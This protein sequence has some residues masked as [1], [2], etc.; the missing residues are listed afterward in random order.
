VKTIKLLSSFSFLSGTVDE[1]DGT[2]TVVGAATCAGAV[3]IASAEGAVTP[4]T[5]LSVAMILAIPADSVEGLTVVDV[6]LASGRV[7]VNVAW[8]VVV[9]VT[10]VLRRKASL[11][12]TTPIL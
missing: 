4:V 9:N 2:S 1:D 12:T 3:V 6:V 10:S 5:L 7:P 11:L 8:I